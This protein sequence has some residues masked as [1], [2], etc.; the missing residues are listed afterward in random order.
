MN[1]IKPVILCF[2]FFSIIAFGANIAFGEE[3]TITVIDEE[4]DIPLE[5]AMIVS[6][7]GKELFCDSE[8]RAVVEIPSGRPVIVRISY[9]GYEGSRVVLQPGITEYTATL[10]LGGT[11]E[12]QE[13]VIEASRPGSSETVSGQS[14]AISGREL[15]RQSETGI[16]EDVMQAVKLLSG[17]GYVGNYATMPSIRGGE[18]DDITA[19]FDGFY[20]ERPFHWGGAFSIFDPKMVESAQVSHGIFSARYGHTIS[21]LLDIHAKNPSTETAEANLSLS[22]SAANLSLSFPFGKSGGLNLMGRVT[23]WDPFVETAKIFFKEIRFISRAP[24]IRSAALGASYDLSADLSLSVNGFFGI[25]G[26]AAIYEATDFAWNNKIGFL[27]SALNYSPRQNIL[28]RTRVGVGFSQNEMNGIVYNEIWDMMSGDQDMIFS[29]SAANVQGRFDLDWDLGSG[30][31]FSAGVE[32]RY[33]RWERSR[34]VSHT[35]NSD[36]VIAIDI[37]NQG[38]TSS[39][40]AILE[41]KSANRRFGI[42]A[43]IRG[44]HF[45][46]LGEDFV[47]KGIP[48]VNPRLN[49]NFNLLENKGIIDALTLTAGTGL[50]SSVNNVLQNISGR[51]GIDPLTETQNRSWNNVIG[52]KIDFDGGYS[53]ILEGYV[54]LVFKRAYTKTNETGNLRESDYFFDGEAFI[55]GFDCMLQKFSSRYWDG[56]ISYSF[57]NAKY[58]DPQSTDLARNNGDWYYPS[59]HRFHTLNVIFNYKPV[60]AVQLTTRFSLASGVP[61]PRVERIYYDGSRYQ[62]DLVYDDM[63]RTG[64]A[65]PLDIKLSLF[66]SQKNGKVLRELYV[67]IENIFSLFYTAKGWP[68]IDS[69]TG[70]KTSYHTMATYE[71]PV[72]MLTFGIKWSY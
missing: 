15:A 29:D 4:L 20:V 71:L 41:Y 51:D 14:V 60:P 30:F 61:V 22:T 67:S 72:P 26:I 7:D 34:H 28:F 46:L 24:Y 16:L 70:E 32:E 45:L 36:P 68:D 3:L 21:G 48:V 69:A 42:E 58:R 62:W 47:L 44:D 11:M 38:F 12:A 43:G 19:V 39:L 31:V 35:G 65:I 9:P 25:D 66:G 17:V 49:L 59:F 55:W 27:T 6:W 50:F 5:G 40:Y 23:Y 54:K 64:V 52:A 10:R 56:W 8:G 37:L 1:L 2:L 33:S 63:S 53:F 18:P 57:I 13:L